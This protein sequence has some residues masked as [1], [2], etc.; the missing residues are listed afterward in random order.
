MN[1]ITKVDDK[2]IDHYD[3]PINDE[4]EHQYDIPINN[5]NNQLIPPTARSRRRTTVNPLVSL[6]P[7]L[8]SNLVAPDLVRSCN[9]ANIGVGKLF[10][11]KNELILELRK[12]A[13]QEKF[14]FKIVQSITTRFEAHCSS[15]SCN[16][17]LRATRVSDDHN[18]P[19]VVR[20]VDNVHTCSNEI[21]IGGL[22]QVKSQVV[23]HLIADKFIQDKRI[24]TL[25]DIRADM[26]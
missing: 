19:W 2:G 24:Y 25:N 18:V 17:R 4:D 8:P 23:G 11:E 21:L 15:E 20:I 26:Q 7:V 10:A 14:D 1:S 6:T 9:S 13:L 3:I 12:V 5:R 22:R 16:W